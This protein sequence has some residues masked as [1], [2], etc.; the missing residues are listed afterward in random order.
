MSESS[1]LILPLVT[2]QTRAQSENIE[3]IVAR[4]RSGRLQIPD[5]Q[6]DNDQWDQRKES[7]F[8]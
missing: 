6:R 2:D 7:L 1:P 8:Y 5:Y 4:L 3:T